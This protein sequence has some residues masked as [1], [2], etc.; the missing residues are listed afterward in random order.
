MIFYLLHNITI[1]GDISE[2][3]EGLERETY[4]IIQENQSENLNF[5][6]ERSY[7]AP[8]GR[9]VQRGKEKRVSQNLSREKN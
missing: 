3:I 5:T 2:Y 4:R 1:N 9:K 7:P 6:F 8:A